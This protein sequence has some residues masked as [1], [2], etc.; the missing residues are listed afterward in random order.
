[1]HDFSFF[2]ILGTVSGIIVIPAGNASNNRVSHCV[3][4]CSRFSPGRVAHYEH[5]LVDVA[6]THFNRAG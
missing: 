1:M 3:L 5:K 6:D 2:L 4:S